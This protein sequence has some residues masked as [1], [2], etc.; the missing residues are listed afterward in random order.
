MAYA[1]AER[2]VCSKMRYMGKY[3]SRL[4]GIT[5]AEIIARLE[6]SRGLLALSSRDLFFLD[7][8][9]NQSAALSHIR[10]IGVNKQS[11]NVDV[12]GEQGALMHIPPSAFQKDELKLFLE[13]L[14]GHVMRA[15]T[16][17]VN[18]EPVEPE[19]I[20]F[21]PAPPARPTLPELASSA[22]DDDPFP[23]PAHEDQVVLPPRDPTPVPDFEP[24]RFM[25]EAD[26]TPMHIID[27]TKTLPDDPNSIWAYEGGAQPIASQEV[28]T[29]PGS[30]FNPSS[31]ENLPAAA[32]V[33][34]PAVMAA[35]AVS[36]NPTQRTGFM[37]LK[38]WALVTLLFA[39]A[40]LALNLLNPSGT[41]AMIS[42]GVLV[43]G[44]ALALI[45]W[46]LSEPL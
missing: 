35:A 46:R 37:L 16:E 15:K 34:A 31:E 32:A 11:G 45:Q 38:V 21:T 23:I 26:E 14:K 20:R 36:P 9:S 3:D 29:H 39:V 42:V 30:Q 25:P 1:H 27:P 28:S 24:P 10:R 22:F 6:G 8:T 44:V 18:P 13:S 43:G 33:A 4:S 41:D 12:S 40:Y 7:D 19:P 2:N 17:I 5:N